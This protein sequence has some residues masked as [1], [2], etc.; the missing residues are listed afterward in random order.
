M[1]WYQA[2]KYAGIV[3]KALA[4]VTS[5]RSHPRLLAHELANLLL[6][7]LGTAG[8]LPVLSAQDKQDLEEAAEVIVRLV[9]KP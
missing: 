5:L 1:K 2:M 3:V 4:L 6:R 8:V 7:S 9:V